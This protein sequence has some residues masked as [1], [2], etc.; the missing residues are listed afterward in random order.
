[1]WGPQNF[2]QIFGKS[3]APLCSILNDRS[4]ISGVKI[5]QYLYKVVYFFFGTPG[6]VNSAI[7]ISLLLHDYP[8]NYLIN[9]SRFHKRPGRFK[10]RHVVLKIM[11]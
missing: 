9:Q 7:D 4:H 6:S 3:S 5:E 10:G 1:M 11:I 8:S 2:C